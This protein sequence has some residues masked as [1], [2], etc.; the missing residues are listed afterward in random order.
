MA[1]W[2]SNSCYYEVSSNIQ[3]LIIFF[4]QNNPIFLKKVFIRLNQNNHD[5]LTNCFCLIV[6]FYFFFYRL[7]IIVYVL[8]RYDD[9]DAVSSEEVVARAM[10]CDAADKPDAT[11]KEVCFFG[12][13]TDSSDDIELFIWCFCNSSVCCVATS[14]CRA[15]LQFDFGNMK[16]IRISKIALIVLLLWSSMV[17]ECF[18][19]S[20]IRVMQGE[21]YL[22]LLTIWLDKP[23][24]LGFRCTVCHQHLARAQQRHR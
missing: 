22:F 11:W 16:Q 4:F 8:I 12:L 9:L 14:S 19:R 13:L 21:I 10:G 3:L 1:C 24:R 15:R 6:F 5:C 7:I 23:Y 20:S 18:A 2:T 17:D